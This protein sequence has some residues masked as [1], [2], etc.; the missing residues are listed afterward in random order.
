MCV[1]VVCMF[2]YLCSMRFYPHLQDTGGFFVALLRKVGEIPKGLPHSVMTVSTS[3][4]F[5]FALLPGRLSRV[6]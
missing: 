3:P 2:V 1:C 6:C 5:V 4:R